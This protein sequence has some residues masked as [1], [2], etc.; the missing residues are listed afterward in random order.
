MCG[1]KVPFHVGISVPVDLIVI[2]FFLKSCI[3]HRLGCR[4]MKNFDF[5]DLVVVLRNILT[6]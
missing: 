2:F 4:L 5:I 3:F 6:S 1:R